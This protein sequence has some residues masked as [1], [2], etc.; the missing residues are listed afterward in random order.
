MASPTKAYA[1]AAVIFR[2]RFQAESAKT[3]LELGSGGNITSFLKKDFALTLPNISGPMLTESKKQNPDL[4]HIESHMRLLCLGRWRKG[5][6]MHLLAL[7]R[8]RARDPTTKVG[9]RTRLTLLQE[10]PKRDAK[11]GARSDA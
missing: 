2:K 10:D 11:Q 7:D 5:L 9:V 1:D 8:I 6:L 3:V 4:E